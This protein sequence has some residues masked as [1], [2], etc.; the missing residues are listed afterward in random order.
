V[1]ANFLSLL[2][3]TLVIYLE[4][5]LFC[6]MGRQIFPLPFS[7]GLLSLAGAVVGG[8]TTTTSIK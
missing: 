2:L 1:H 7:L 8:P 6:F 3:L 4:N 5:Q